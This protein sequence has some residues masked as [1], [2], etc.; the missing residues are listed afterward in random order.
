MN[1]DK[2]LFYNNPSSQNPLLI[3]IDFSKS[4]NLKTL[5]ANE[6]RLLA[7]LYLY[8]CPWLKAINVNYFLKIVFV[9][10]FTLHL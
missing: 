10:N 4:I 6:N 9:F 7:K 1:L 5:T 3:D 8:G 2:L